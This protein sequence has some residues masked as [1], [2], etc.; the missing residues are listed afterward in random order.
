MSD[1][2]DLVTL[3]FHQW[4]RLNNDTNNCQ[5]PFNVTNGLGDTNVI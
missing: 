3:F 5:Y 1:K 2:P 4:R